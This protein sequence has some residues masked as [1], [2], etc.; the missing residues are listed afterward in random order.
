MRC[1]P[2]FPIHRWE[3]LFLTEKR[4]TRKTL[5]RLFSYL[6]RHKIILILAGVLTVS[7]NL[8]ALAIPYYS[9]LAIDA[10]QG[11]GQV[12]FAKVF[13]LCMWML[14]FVVANSVLAYLSQFVL[15]RLSSRITR[16]MRQEVF[17]HLL[18]L[19][20]RFYDEHQVGD[21]IS[22]IS[23]DIDTINTSLSS[24]LIQV[25]TS[26]ITVVGSFVMMMRISLPLCIIFV[27]TT[28]LIFYI[29][30]HRAKVVRPL[31]HK[32]S[33]KLGEL[34]GFT[35]EMLSGH[36]TIKAYGQEDNIVR[37]FD[38]KNEE[39][40]ESYYEAD[41]QGSIVGPTVTFINNLSLAMIS[42]LGGF[43][44]L[45]GGISIGNISSFILYSKRF[46][47]PISGM[48]EI[49]AEIQSAISA[50]RRVF[51]LL[52]EPA[53][54]KDK[55]NAVVLERVKGDVVFEHVRFGYLDSKTILH[56]L[57][58]TADHGR[59]IAIVGPTGAGKTTIINLL[60]RFYDPQSGRILIDGTDTRD[61]TRDSLRKQFSMVL[62]DTWLFAGTIYE[63]VSYG[64]DGIDRDAVI[65]ACKAV[66][67]HDFIMSL[68]NGY[69]TVLTD[70]GVNIS[71]GQK[72]LLTIARAMLSDS[73]MLILDEATSNVDSN[74]EKKIQKAMM[75]LCE[76]RT[77]FVIA[78]RLS[79]IREADMILVLQHGRIAEM[80]THKKLLADR[81]F[82]ASMFNA[83]WE[84]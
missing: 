49:M 36:K 81:G 10:I 70:D 50:A 27:I 34:N 57:S 42:G 6:W 25:L 8:A 16:E 3:V 78:H 80:G 48:A 74:T 7:G 32:R 41:Y 55:E 61:C 5:L 22:R 4:N 29:T 13:G 30:R 43:L 45:N 38:E 56:D 53:E 33:T 59:M 72:Q 83:Q 40:V 76:G 67:I 35:E 46:S 65:R 39:A 64:R 31:F 63:N 58:F 28:P 17:D 19:P 68:K 82:Y 73:K 1:M 15:V 84:S 9:G 79:T 47:G 75:K 52:D 37:R 21:V 2:R 26:L 54:I 51:A 77:T 23:Y 24:D 44:F 11:A 18:N 14:G 69:D 60:M 20:V 62:Q 71:K 66:E 12:V